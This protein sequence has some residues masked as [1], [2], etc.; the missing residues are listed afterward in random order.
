[1]YEQLKARFADTFGHEAEHVF[2]APGRTELGG[3]HTDHQLGCVLAAA[4]D[5]D[6]VA[7][8]GRRD[9]TLLCVASEGYPLCRIDLRDTAPRPEE[10][11]TTAALI[12]GVAAAVQRTSAAVP[13]FD[14]CVTSRVLP[15]SGLSSSAAFE[16]LLGTVMNHFSGAG[17]PPVEI[18]KIGQWA[19]NEY[20]GKPCG[21]MDQMASAVGGAVA[22]DF[23]APEGPR[24]TPLRCDFAA[25]GY[26]LC[27]INTGADHAALTGEYAAITE[28]LAAVCRLFGATQLRRVPE[29][30][31]YARLR[32]V[33]SAAGDRAALRAMHVY[34]ENRRVARMV[35]ALRDSDSAAYLR[36]VTASGR[37][38][39]MYLQNVAP[40]GSAAHQE[41]AL[42]LAL[43]EHL[44]A[45][46]GACRVHGGGFAG[47]IQAYVPLETLDAFRAGMEAVLGAGR[48]HVLSVRPSGGVL[49]E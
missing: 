37:S 24:I 44:L 43:A 42:S 27:I 4:V 23:G 1:M 22:I 9:D 7:A 40:S 28:E 11:G 46:R 18:A 3:N 14:A 2:S 19:E 32:E 5:L 38:S 20:F 26:A 39:W 31:F 30:A 12:R 21:L 17:L 15:G 33:R 16:V 36:E 35:R 25:W 41:V 48:C 45:G 47:T 8:A 10:R 6:T 49:V 34:E 29:E 13:G